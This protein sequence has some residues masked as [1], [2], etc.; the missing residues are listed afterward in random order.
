MYKGNALPK[1]TEEYLASHGLKNALYTIRAADLTE[2]LFGSLMP[3][4]LQVR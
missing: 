3:C 1:G 2:D 4:T